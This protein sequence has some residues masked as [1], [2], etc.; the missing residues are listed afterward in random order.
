VRAV[1]VVLR[2]CPVTL[3]KLAA[4]AGVSHA[5]VGYLSRGLRAPTPE[6]SARLASALEDLARDAK[7]GA[8][9]IRKALRQQPR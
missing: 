3:R 1:Q 5:L 6:V 4:R 9:R 7:A 2:S 8:T